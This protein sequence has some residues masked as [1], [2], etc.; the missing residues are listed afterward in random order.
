MNM[1]KIK[2]MLLGI[3]FILLG[4]YG[5][6]MFD[7]TGGGYYVHLLIYFGLFAPP[8]GLIIFLFGFFMKEKPEES[9][10]LEEDNE[11]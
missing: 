9:N 5:T 3:V 10:D 4:I 2:T 8:I 11:K 1:K 7:T 6:S